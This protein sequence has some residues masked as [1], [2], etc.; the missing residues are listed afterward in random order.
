MFINLISRLPLWLLYRVAD[1]IYFVLYYGGV[2]RKQ[3]VLDN[4]RRAFPNLSDTEIHKKAKVFFHHLADL[5]IE[6]LKARTISKEALLKRVK[7]TNPEVFDECCHSGQNYLFLA[8]HHSNWSWLLL[9]NNLKFPFPVDAVHKPQKPLINNFFIKLHSRFGAGL[10]S[11]QSAAIKIVKQRKELRSYAL[12]A[13][14]TPKRSKEKYWTT[15]CGL[16][17]AFHVGPDVLARLTQFPVV[18]VAMH[19]VKRGYYEYSLEIIGQ[20]PY[21]KDNVGV[22]ARYAE[23]FNQHLQAYP[24]HWIWDYNRWT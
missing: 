14:L 10:I 5:L 16:K 9:A 6:T 13:D 23:R 22:M 3:V 8:M 11:S 19:K 21:P 7:I 12:V 15:V 2:Y 1:V 20:P 24:D 17:T 18:F 4:L